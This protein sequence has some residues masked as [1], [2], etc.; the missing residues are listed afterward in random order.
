MIE[1]NPDKDYSIVYGVHE[2][3]Y[4]QNGVLFRADHSVVPGQVL[5]NEPIAPA[6]E[7]KPPE[8][9][10]EEE[11]PA[12]TEPIV[13]PEPQEVPSLSDRDVQRAKVADL[14]RYGD[15]YGM[16]LKGKTR[17]EMIGLIIDAKNSA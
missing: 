16:N 4:E 5:P 15:Y 14:I 17:K 1:F 6:V 9:P 8:P 10:A 13:E 2:A 12:E 7:T 11:K 3:R